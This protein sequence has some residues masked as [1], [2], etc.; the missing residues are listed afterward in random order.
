M[1]YMAIIDADEKPVSCKCI[2]CNGNV[3]PYLSGE[4]TN[5]KPLEQESFINKPCVSE[6]PC[7]HDKN[8]VLDKIA[9]EIT[10]NSYLSYDD[11]PRHIIDE[12]WVLEIIDKHRKESE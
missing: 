9:K 2:G 4:T 7:E 12:D 1:K 6:K 11:N 8:V 3:V 5:I 10:D